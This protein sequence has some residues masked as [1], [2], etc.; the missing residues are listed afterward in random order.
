MNYFN[1]LVRCD[2]GLTFIDRT[3]SNLLTYFNGRL[4]YDN[5]TFYSTTPSSTLTEIIT[6]TSRKLI[7]P[8]DQPIL[9]IDE[10]LNLLRRK[11]KQGDTILRL[12]QETIG[13]KSHINLPKLSEKKQK[14]KYDFIDEI[15]LDSHFGYLNGVYIGDGWVSDTE[16][17]HAIC[18]ASE[19]SVIPSKVK[20]IIDRYL[21]KE[22]LHI[23]CV[24]NVHEYEGKESYSEK[25]TWHSDQFARYL[26][27]NIGTGQGAINKRLPYYWTETSDSYRWGLLAG[28][29]DTDGSIMKNYQKEQIGVNYTTISEEL[30]NNI[31]RLAGSLNLTATITYSKTP[32]GKD[33]YYITFTQESLLKMKGKLPLIKKWEALK[34]FIPKETHDRNKY[35]PKL[36]DSR[37]S[38]LRA[39]IGSPRLKSRKGTPLFRT[40]TEE[41]IIRDKRSLYQILYRVKHDNS[42]ITKNTARSILNLG[43]DIMNDPFWRKWEELSTTD[44]YDWELI[45]KIIPYES[46][47]P[48]NVYK[49]DLEEA[50]ALVDSNGIIY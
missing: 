7:I 10:D 30:A 31:I 33:C 44:L 11:P 13:C 26:K 17:K 50:Q 27:D 9:V 34:E 23:S 40:T 14:Q 49:A 3:S 16:V 25:H 29:I 19:D 12:R 18:L 15:P 28:L 24:P 46:P 6:N 2:N 5:V 41:Q 20:E 38:E 35:T 1:S 39:V 36:S 8:S 21:K 22:K 42:A 43:L 37:L 47:V 4:S 48:L 45:T 32:K